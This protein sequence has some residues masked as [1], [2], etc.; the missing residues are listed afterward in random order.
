MIMRENII[1]IASQGLTTNAKSVMQ[2]TN[3]TNSVEKLQSLSIRVMIELNSE[4][5]KYGINEVVHAYAMN[6]MTDP[7]TLYKFPNAGNPSNWQPIGPA[8]R[9]AFAADFLGADYSKCQHPIFS[10][11]FKWTLFEYSPL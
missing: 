5:S 6:V 1:T 10:T 3:I 7:A 9:Y 11:T 4:A 8:T 2:T